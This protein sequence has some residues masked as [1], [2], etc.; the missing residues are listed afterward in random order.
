MTTIGVLALQGGFAEHASVI[1][2]LGSTAS[3]VRTIHDLS[4]VSGL[5]IPGGES[6]TISKLLNARGLLEP[7]ASLA[8]S[9][10][11]TLGTCAGLIL[12]AHSIDTDPI[13]TLNLLDI[14]V[15]RNGYGRQANSFE[16]PINIPTLGPQPLQG[17][18]I[19]APII[20]HIGP[21]VETIATLPD[22][23]PVAVRTGNILGTAFHPELTEDRR[24]H[25]MFVEL[26]KDFARSN[27]VTVG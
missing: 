7:I 27:N 4:A 12:M 15:I 3:E 14:E 26:A 23:T 13:P 9:G 5:I 2:S 8:R 19:R 17:V 6:T 24:I 20:K 22:A 11:P 25:T 16:A 18:F 1:N 21:Q 10:M